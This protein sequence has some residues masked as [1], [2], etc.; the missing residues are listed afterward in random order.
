MVSFPHFSP[1]KACAPLSPAPVRA[2]CPAHLI[3]KLIEILTFYGLEM[4][5]E[6]AKVM[7]T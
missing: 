2:K 3:D 7:I 1:P 6:N 4:E 5:V